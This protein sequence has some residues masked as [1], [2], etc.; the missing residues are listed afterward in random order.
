MN[1]QIMKYCIGYFSLFC[2]VMLSSL[3]MHATH[4][5]G[6]DI[7][8]QCLG[9][10]N[11]EITLTIRRD[12]ENGL[13][14]AD[15][16]DPVSIG[17]F[18][19]VFGNLLTKYGSFGQIF[20]PF[21]EADTLH[22]TIV[23]D[24]GFIG[25]Q[26]CVEETTY[27][28][29]VKLP[30][31]PRGLILAHQRCC[32]NITLNNIV[33]PLATGSTYYIEV[34]PEAL[35]ECNS[36]PSF[37]DW[38]DLYICANQDLSFSLSAT[39]IDGDSLVYRLCTPSTG[40]D[41]SDPMP[42]PPSPPP[43]GDVQFSFP[44]TL[45]NM[46][47]GVP[48]QINSETGQLTANPNLVGQYLIG[49]CVDEYRNGKLMS[50]VRR[51]FEYNVRVCSV[52]PEASYVVDPPYCGT[53]EVSFENTSTDSD[54]YIWYFDYPSTDPAF[55]STEVNPTFNFPSSGLYNVRLEAKR[56]ID[57][58]VSSFSNVIAVSTTE[59]DAEI[60][61]NITKC[62]GNT[63]TLELSSPTIDNDP[64]FDVISYHWTIEQDGTIT[65]LSGQSIDVDILSDMPVEVS[66][67]VTSS[68]GCF[69]T[70]IL[71]ITNSGENYNANFTST[72]IDCKEG[73][74]VIEFNDIS[75][76]TPL[77]T[78]AW[79]WTI[80]DNGNTII[81][82]QQSFEAILIDPRSATALLEI[83]L[84]NGCKTDLFLDNLA[85]SDFPVIDFDV[86]VASCD[87]TELIMSFSD[88]S[89]HGS[90]IPVSFDWTIV[91]DSG[92]TINLSGSDVSQAY[93]PGEILDINLS[94]TYNNGCII[95][96]DK[97]DIDINNVITPTSFVNELKNCN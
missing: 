33:D 12:C 19:P 10:D 62:D 1:N 48:L 26:V 54:S 25:S 93:I 91:S 60:E 44:F 7:S 37:D 29:V 42:Q 6:G 47:G 53:S 24:C 76:N 31:R 23:S 2:L 13:P 32:R 41:A 90:L 20:I 9:D 46:M 35:T 52:G 56:T 45:D 68:S 36:S 72:F 40:A 58:C 14:Q 86:E 49:V 70:E 27:K 81:S 61:S 30:Y 82:D 55:T 17:V 63:V 92:S 71:N 89:D 4:I 34:T 8:Y 87:N 95:S 28:T 73:G 75:E 51:D 65:T 83:T 80:V 59:L 15:F 16:D 84:S 11:Y 69:D 18:D 88:S 3:D 67:T 39:D 74:F 22:E 77:T 94:V 57:G 79:N 5:V 50:S 21:S 43:Y 96:T 78:T 85:V 38:A 97:N 66:L 64:V